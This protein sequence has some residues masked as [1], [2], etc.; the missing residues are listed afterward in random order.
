MIMFVDSATRVI[1]SVARVSAVKCDCNCV[2]AVIKSD[3]SDRGCGTCECIEEKGTVKELFRASDAGAD[4]A[5]NTS[6]TLLK[7]RAVHQTLL[8]P[9]KGRGGQAARGEGVAC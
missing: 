2:L 8:A 5:R 9:T 1:V 3:L 7:G 6:L 4:F